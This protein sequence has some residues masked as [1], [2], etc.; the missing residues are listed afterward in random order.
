MNS[1]I[2]GS[3]IRLTVAAAMIIGA[4]SAMTAS[5]ATA[6]KHKVKP[7]CNLV[8]DASGDAK[9]VGGTNDPSMDILSADVATDRKRITAVIRVAGLSTGTDMQSPSG[10][11]WRITMALP[12]ANN[13]QLSLGV[14][15][16]PFGTRDADNIGGKAT[17][18]TKHHQVVITESLKA[19]A[20]FHAHI[21][22]GKTR[23]TQFS[24]TSSS[25]I[26]LPAVGGLWAS[27]SPLGAPTDSASGNATY[28]AG[29]L[30]CVKPG[31]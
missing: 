20:G 15:T 25:I 5:A 11:E 18:D 7:V 27:T 23:L 9:D 22:F 13:G 28:L 26:Q 8:T 10:R 21:V 2:G 16:G 1:T 4:G 12:G 24:A 14:Q 19:L 30:S 29:A 6:R 3:A 17:L 31:S